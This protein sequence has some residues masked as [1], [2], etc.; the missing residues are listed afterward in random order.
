MQL[1]IKDHTKSNFSYYR[2]CEYEDCIMKEYFMLSLLC[3]NKH[4]P[5]YMTLFFSK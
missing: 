2:P 4:A 5:Y 1:V 3:C